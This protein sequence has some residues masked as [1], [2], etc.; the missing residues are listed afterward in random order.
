MTS[1]RVVLHLGS[2]PAHLGVELVDGA[3][4]LLHAPVIV[5]RSQEDARQHTRGNASQHGEGDYK[6][7]FAPHWRRRRPNRACSV[8]ASQSL[9]APRRDHDAKRDRKPDNHEAQLVLVHWSTVSQE[10]PC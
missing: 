6:P 5:A 7:P 9:R 3:L 8:P 2:Q 4:E 1:V 10:Q